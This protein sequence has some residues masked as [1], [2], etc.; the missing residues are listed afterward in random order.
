[1][2]Q[3][4]VKPVSLA[5]SIGKACT[6]GVN[7]ISDVK[8]TLWIGKALAKDAEIARLT[9][10]HRIAEGEIKCCHDDIK[11]LKA[12][13]AAYEG[14]THHCPQCE[15]KAGEMSVLVGAL[16]KVKRECEVADFGN[17]PEGRY[18]DMKQTDLYD[19][20]TTALSSA[21]AAA[22]KLLAVVEAAKDV[23]HAM[24]GATRTPTDEIDFAITE[25]LTADLRRLQE[26]VR[27]L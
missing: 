2:E 21:P 16:G 18:L 19:Y 10:A 20:V 14:D 25:A 24:L 7:E 5:D 15:E 4:I 13:L 17:D 8:L 9:E 22:K 27:T 1:M 26:A 11:R 23:E 6:G 3:P 12:R